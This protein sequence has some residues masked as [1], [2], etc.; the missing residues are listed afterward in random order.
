MKKTKEEKIQY[1]IYQQLRYMDKNPPKP[2]KTLEEIKLRNSKYNKKYNLKYRK[3]ENYKLNKERTKLQNNIHGQLIA[4]L[5]GKRLN[6]RSSK[7]ERKEK[8]INAK[9]KHRYGNFSNTAKELRRLQKEIKC[10]EKL[11][12]EKQ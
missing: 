1:A 12:R 3:T 7:Q 2:R 11:G 10:L 4:M 8:A 6:P 5:N 9:Y